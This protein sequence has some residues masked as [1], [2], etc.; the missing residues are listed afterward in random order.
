[1]RVKVTVEAARDRPWAAVETGWLWH[2]C[3]EHGCEAQ[4]LVSFYFDPVRRA[5]SS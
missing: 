1:L 5:R 3:R 4:P 2:V